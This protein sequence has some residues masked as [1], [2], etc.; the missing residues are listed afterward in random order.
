MCVLVCVG[1]CVLWC[2]CVCAGMCA[3]VHASRIIYLFEEVV[4]NDIRL[5]FDVNNFQL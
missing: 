1:M 5:Y 2:V 3:C 4:L